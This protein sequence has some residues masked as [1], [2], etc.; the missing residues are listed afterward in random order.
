MHPLR[1][2]AALAFVAPFVL[3]CGSNSAPAT[4]PEVD[5]DVADSSADSILDT[6]SSCNATDPRSVPL[7]VNVQ[8]DESDTPIVTA[9]G[10]AEKSIRVMIYLM[11]TGNILDTLKK[12]ATEGKSVQIILDSSQKSVNQK[13]YD[14][15]AASGAK[16]QWSDTAFTYMHAKILVIDDKE[17]IISTGN[18]ALSYIQ[19]ERNF[20]ARDDDPAD[21]AS[22]AALFDADWNRKAPD[23]S[24]TRLVVSPI[25]SRA[26]ILA[27]I[28]S[29]TKSIV[30][31]SMQLADDDVRNA[32]A[33]RKT[34]GVD[35][36]VLVAD[37]SWVDTNT[38]AAVFCSN[39]GIPAK[40]LAAPAIHVKA[41][42]VDG[43]RA[44]LGSEN[45]TFTSLNKNREVGLIASEPDVVKTMSDTFEKDWKIATSF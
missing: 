38:D 10:K 2:L 25:N 27:L 19:K 43:A 24:C 17:A 35:V 4:N 23:L 9:L 37:P 18:F 45:L 20:V 39:Y 33:K 22:L 34:A 32:I 12:K 11:G 1:L 28:D 26:R 44:Y 40:W 16:V 14:Q 7:V 30:V 15:L 5:S 8:P 6:T 3:G 31:E 36:R 42:V 29:A 13:Y 21:V 41:I